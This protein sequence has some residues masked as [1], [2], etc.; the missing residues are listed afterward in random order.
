[1]KKFTITV[2]ENFED[3]EF[4]GEFTAESEDKAE[5]MAREFYAYELGCEDVDIA[6]MRTIE[7]E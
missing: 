4:T 5:R 6:I 7:N 3:K 1:M 2:Y